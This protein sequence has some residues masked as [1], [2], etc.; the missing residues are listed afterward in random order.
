VRTFDRAEVIVPNGNLVRA[1]VVNWT[2]SDRLR[3]LEIPVGVAYGTDFHRVLEILVK[4]AQKHPD[5]LE[6]PTP[7]ELFRS[8]RDR[9]LDFYV[10]VSREKASAGEAKSK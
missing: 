1:E 9:S 10:S 5:V 2:L 8:F 3:R 4:V 6:H 7:Q